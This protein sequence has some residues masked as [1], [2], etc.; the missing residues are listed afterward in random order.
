L[1][2]KEKGIRGNV[3]ACFVLRT[4]VTRI[5]FVFVCLFVCFSF[6]CSN[7]LF[8]FLLFDQLAPEVN[9]FRPLNLKLFAFCV[10]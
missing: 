5:A 8:L 10:R 6:A 9:P 1:S 3:T 2:S 7:V 4:N